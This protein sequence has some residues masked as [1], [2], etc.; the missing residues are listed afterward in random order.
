MLPKGLM[1]QV[2]AT[3]SASFSIFIAGSWV[4]WPSATHKSFENHQTGV[5]INHTQ[6]SW[7][8]SCMDLGNFFIPLPA[9]YLMDRFGRKNTVIFLG[10]LY[11]TSWTLT[12]LFDNVW[13]L[14]IARLLGGAGK[15]ISYTVVPIFLGEI[16]EVKIRGALSTIFA[17]QLSFG[18]FFELV[19]SNIVNY[20]TLNMISTII[21]IIFFLTFIWVPESPF[22]LLKKNRRDEAAKCLRWYRGG[23]DS[24]LQK[25]ELNVQEDMKNKGT[26]KELFTN[27][28]NLRV[29]C[30]IIIACFSQRAGGISNLIA[31]G[32]YTLP[33]SPPLFDSTIYM[34]IF[35]AFQVIFGFVGMSL[36]DVLGR[37]PLLIISQVSLG[38]ITF[39]HGLYFFF[40]TC[41]H[42]NVSEFIWVPCLCLELF[43]IMFS[44]G[45]GFIPVVL[46]GEMLPVNVRA[47]GSAVMSMTLAFF[48]FLA[49]KIFL[50][51]T[52]KFGCYVMFWIYSMVNLT[53]A[54]LI[55]KMA[56]ETKGKTFSEIQEIL[57]LR[58]K[59]KKKQQSIYSCKT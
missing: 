1:N 13:A 12:W 9:G 57:E 28:K 38:L 27:P 29:I 56:F 8:V 54:F 50:G 24:E 32:I 39:V 19:F 45:I 21:P 46:L 18:L 59:P 16:A 52:D 2:F 47:H 49:N 33:K 22:Y 44:V 55:Y 6:L 23:E 31:F 20:R 43:S 15:G 37:K 14:Y 51:I 17:I 35:G 30:I 53:S 40:K 7:V 41:M 4:G 36:V 58:I 5:E 11:I 10:P 26:Y 34:I 42:V 3:I 25:M 48:S